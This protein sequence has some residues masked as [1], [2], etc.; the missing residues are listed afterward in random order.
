MC[1]FCVKHGD[2][3]KWYMAM[4]NYAKDLRH[5]DNRIGYM[6]YFAN[7]FEERMPRRLNQLEKLSRT[8]LRNVV[9]PFLIRSQKR[10]HFGQIV[11]LEDI[12]KILLRLDGICRLSCPCRRLTT[13]QKH[14]RYCYALTADPQLAA[15]IDDSFNLEVMTSKEAIESV[16]ALDEE[17]LIHTVWTFKTP[18]IGALCNC[19]QDCL[20]YRISY[21]RNYFRLMFRSEYVAVLDINTCNGCRNCMRHCNFG[22]IR[23]SAVNKK[24]EIDARRCFGCGVCRATCHKDAITL[25][26]R[27]SDPVAAKIW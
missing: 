3:K 4:E 12:E 27:S 14:A 13:G 10:N 18:Y 1:E 21:S 11:P 17:G 24:V 25:H 9:R 20:A 26:A 8:P 5:Q 19:D 6:G 15:E 22:A 23:Y 2:G 16:R 7:T